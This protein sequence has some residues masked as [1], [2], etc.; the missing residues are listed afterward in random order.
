MAKNEFDGAKAKGQVITIT[1]E[2]RS[3]RPAGKS[4]AGDKGLLSRFDLLSRMGE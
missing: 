1:Q 4:Q 2:M 3:D